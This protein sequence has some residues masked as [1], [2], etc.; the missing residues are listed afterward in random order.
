MQNTWNTKYGP[1][2]VKVA[3][4]TLAE[5]VAAAKDMASD[6]KS[7]IEIA[8]ALMGMSEDEVRPEV[9]KARSITLK[10]V[11][12]VSSSNGAARQVVVERVVSRR[13]MGAV[14]KFGS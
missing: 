10:P 1:R 7:Q 8:A 14:R 4:P 2:R 12:I 5:A 9:L 6:T 11:R 13:P 3:L